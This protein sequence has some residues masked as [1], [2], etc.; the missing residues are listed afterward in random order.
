MDHGPK[1][2]KLSNGITVILRENHRLP[3][4]ALSAC[5]LGGLLAENKNNNGGYHLWAQCI[6]RGTQNR[7]Q[8]EIAEAVENMAGQ[9]EGF[10][11]KN[12]IG[13]RLEML[14]EYQNDGLDLLAEILL[15]PA[16]DKSEFE[17]EK[18]LTLEAIK[19][20]EDNLSALAFYHFQKTLFKNHPYGMRVMGEKASL[21]KLSTGGIK[22]LHQKTI[23]AKNMVLSV[24]GDFETKK[25]IGLLE[26]KLAGIGKNSFD[27]RR[28]APV[29][30]LSKIEKVS[31]PKEKEQA[32]LV[33]G[34]TAPS[35]T[36][37]DHYPMTVLN[38][39]LSGM[40]GRLFVELRDKMSLAYS[41]TSVFS[42]GLDPGY[43]AV[44]LGTEPSKIPVALK[45]IEKELQKITTTQVER[46]ELEK[47]KN[48]LVG[49]YELELQRNST[50]A[51]AF[52][53]DELYGIGFQEVLRYPE[54]ILKISADDIL[55]VAKKYIHLKA[56]VLSTVQPT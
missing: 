56:Y 16:W 30:K 25:L 28:R 24:V 19:N 27:G 18:R 45:A 51:Q 42:P 44:Y 38:N 26:K 34:F 2:I 23:V 1:K 46:D 31:V 48:H 13:L 17:K 20:Q 4:V 29:S 33:L 32:H 54:K 35:F 15:E 39:L 6:T 10:S 50:Q 22:K 21:I 8:L 3:I 9:L 11:G 12:S 43:F 37:P 7:S 40:G 47:T 52:S 49:T 5:F 41:I 14:S 53:L 36:N 55:C